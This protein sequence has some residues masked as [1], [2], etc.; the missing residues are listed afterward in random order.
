MKIHVDDFELTLDVELSAKW[1][2]EQRGMRERGSGI[3]LE[4]DEPAHWEILSVEC[5]GMDIT[6]LLSDD[7]FDR[8]ENMLGDGDGDER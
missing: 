8:L 2:K 6:K 3:Q 7:D 5:A 4:P 1:H